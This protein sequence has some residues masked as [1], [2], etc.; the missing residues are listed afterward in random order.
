M[1][2][3]FVL[4]TL[5]CSPS[6][7]FATSGDTDDN[8]SNVYPKVRDSGGGVE[9]YSTLQSAYNASVNGDIIESQ[10]ANFTEDLVIDIGKSVTLQGGYNNDYTAVTGKTTLN[11]NLN[12]ANGTV[13]IS[14]F[15]LQ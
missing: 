10:T 3:L 9:Y 14:D 5:A 6:V 11:G 2:L 1:Q 7:V 13:T 8:D 4:H 12:I 15:I